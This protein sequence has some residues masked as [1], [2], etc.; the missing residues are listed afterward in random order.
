MKKIFVTGG[1]GFVGQHVIPIL[2]AN[3]FEVCAIARSDRSAKLVKE[4]GAKPVKDDLTALTEATKNAL[5]QC[6]Y[7]LHSAA[8]MD[9]TYDPEPFIKLNVEA[10]QHLL[11][12]SKAAGIQKFIYISAAPVI[13]GSPIIRLTEAKAQKGLPKAL[14]PRTKAIAERSVLDANSEDFLTLALRPPA[15]W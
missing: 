9:F 14:Y 10:T 1:S 12:L 3:G 11:Q 8:H 5:E 4:L 2:I 7:V 13:P 6:D 15:I